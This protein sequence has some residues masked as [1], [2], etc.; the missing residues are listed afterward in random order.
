[1]TKDYGSLR[2]ALT[3]SFLGMGF[4]RVAV[5]AE[6]YLIGGGAEGHRGK[7]VMQNSE[8]LPMVLPANKRKMAHPPKTPG[9][10]IFVSLFLIMAAPQA[11]A[12]FLFSHSRQNA[13]KFTT[14]RQDPWFYCDHN[15]YLIQ[16]P[17]KWQHYMSNY[18]FY[19]PTEKIIGRWQAVAL[20]TSLD[21]I[22]EIEDGYRE[23]AS[24]RDFTADIL[25]MLAAMAGQKLVCTYNN[26]RVILKYNF[27]IPLSG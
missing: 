25:G 22:K 8:E 15:E 4:A 6:A 19:R 21:V 16:S 5:D 11:E 24:I 1:M 9:I 10:V 14:A 7:S 23:G 2:K 12:G 26:E 3:G 20:F 13:F 18:L 27:S 17:D